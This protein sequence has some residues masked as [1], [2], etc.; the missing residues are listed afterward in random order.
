M[1]QFFIL[2][3]LSLAITVNIFSQVPNSGVTQYVFEIVVGNSQGTCF[4]VAD[5]NQSYLVTARHLFE[6]TLNQSFIN[7]SIAYDTSWQQMKGQVFFHNDSNVDVAIIKI[8]QDL[9]G[10]KLKGSPGIVFGQDSYFLGFPF[11]IRVNDNGNINNNYPLPFM[12]KATIGAIYKINKIYYL[13]MD[14]NNNGGFSGGPVVVK[15]L[16]TASD[17][18]WYLAGVVKGYMKQ[19]D[20]TSLEISLPSNNPKMKNKILHQQIQY[21]ENSGIMVATETRYIKEIIDQI[22]K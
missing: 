8:N 17:Q 16:L 9:G 11:G 2:C 18:S 1:K 5:S 14:G 13:L 6:K 12:K 15:N 19:I 10:I 22:R 3:A 4:M 7:F 20:S 21:F